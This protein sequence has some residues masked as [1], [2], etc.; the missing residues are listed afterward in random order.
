MTVFD[1]TAQ[2]LNA[3]VGRQ[4]MCG[5]TGQCRVSQGNRGGI[6]HGGDQALAI[7]SVQLSAVCTVMTRNIR[8]N[9]RLSGMTKIPGGNRYA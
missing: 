7:L 6:Q 9:N 1:K 2:R 5:K 3:G 4:D 8:H